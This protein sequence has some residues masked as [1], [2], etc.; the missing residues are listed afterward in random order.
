MRATAGDSRIRPEYRTVSGWVDGGPLERLRFIPA[1]ARGRMR[2][3]VEA[4]A[5]AR[6]PRPDV[7]WTSVDEVLAPYFWSQLGPL[8]RPLVLDLDSSPEQLEQDAQL[9]FGRA[10]HTGARRML[11]NL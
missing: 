3:V 8:R 9:Y 5:I 6:L 4:A 11:A 2:A 1:G 7:I 10:P